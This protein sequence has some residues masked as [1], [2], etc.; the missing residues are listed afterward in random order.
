MS[1]AAPESE[2]VARRERK[3]RG[4]RLC[5]SGAWA[6]DIWHPIY[7]DKVCIGTF[8]N[9]EEAS[10][11]Y[12]NHR[13]FFELICKAHDLGVY[14]DLLLTQNIVEDFDALSIAD[15][16]PKVL[17]EMPPQ[18]EI[19]VVDFDDGFVDDD[20]FRDLLAN[21]SFDDSVVNVYFCFG[22]SSTSLIM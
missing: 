17:D 11:A 14:H 1:R 20:P 16:E 10:E 18:D 2:T 12:E 4:V 21:A 9:A 19:S 13:L 5:D 6:V 3:Y 15:A 22:V 7:K 8:N